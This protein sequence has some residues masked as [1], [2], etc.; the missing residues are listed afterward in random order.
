MALHCD[1]QAMRLVFT[2]TDLAFHALPNFLNQEVRRI[3]PY[4]IGTVHGLN[5]YD[6]PEDSIIIIFDAS[7]CS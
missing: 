5:M 2:D 1:A 6:R 3:A 4:E 7:L